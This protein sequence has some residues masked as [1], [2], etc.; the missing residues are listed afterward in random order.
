VS[1]PD[2]MVIGSFRYALGRQTYVVGETAQWL[3]AN[4]NTLSENARFVIRRDLAEA[5]ARDD[6]ARAME[7]VRKNGHKFRELG[8][9]MDRAEWMKLWEKIK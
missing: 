7:S 6:K 3:A 1:P 2:F 9:D 4:W 5:I 8:A